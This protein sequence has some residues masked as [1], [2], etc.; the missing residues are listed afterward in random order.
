MTANIVEKLEEEK[1]QLKKITPIDDYFLKPSNYHRDTWEKNNTKERMLLLYYT[2]L[3]V[4]SL[5]YLV[6]LI[7]FVFSL[8]L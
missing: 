5:S 3:A 8:S 2:G 6:Y 1:F 7:T 4:V